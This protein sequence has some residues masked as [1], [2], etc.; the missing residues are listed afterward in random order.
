[1]GKIRIL[2]ARSGTACPLNA[3]QRIRIINTHGQQVVDT[4]A[5]S[6]AD[7]TE[8]MAMDAT[9]VFNMRMT[10]RVGD[11]LITNRR[12]EILVL[13]EDTSPGRHDTMMAACDRWRYR[14]LGFEGVHDNCAD[15]LASAMAELGIVVTHTPAPLNLFMN[16]PWDDSG[17]LGFEPPLSRPGDHVVL[18]AR[19]DCIVAMSA[20]PQDMVPVNG[21]SCQPTEAHFEIIPGN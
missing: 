15:N 9:R 11:A 18:R 3:G 19:M 13:D 4:W 5:F 2:P 12:R 7:S 1:M 14:L 17:N 16:I 6:T 8:F 10:P 21:E 20:C